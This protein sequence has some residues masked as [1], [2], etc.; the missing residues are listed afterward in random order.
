ME[1]EATMATKTISSVL[2]GE[3]EGEGEAGFIPHFRKGGKWG[4]ELGKRR[5]C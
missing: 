4:F 3:G 2:A 1:A 5:R